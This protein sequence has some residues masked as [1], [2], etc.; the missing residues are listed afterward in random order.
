MNAKKLFSL[1]IALFGEALIIL[2][3]L[4]FGGNLESEIL[5]LNIVVSSIIYCLV[6]VDFIF[7]WV[8][9]KDKEQ[10]QIGSIGLRWFFT[11]L[12]LALAIGAMVIF[13][14]TKPIHFTNQIII[15]GV[16][17]FVVLLG[18]FLAYSSSDKVR[19]IYFEEKQNRDRIDEMK[20]ATK[21]LQLKLDAINNIP[22]EIISRINEL[23]ENLRYLSPSN[24]NDALV[25]ETKFLDDVKLLF[26]CFSDSP[27]NM[28]A[29]ISN[30]KNCERTYKER[31]QVFSN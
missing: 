10:K 2:G 11:Y 30:I 17:F 28:E 20:R 15:H 22:T 1:F 6:F 23:H 9:L 12:Y 14:T 21:E 4:H 7:P 8:K 16:M 18:L 26:Y 5:T 25:L 3:F 24:N 19:E 27:I 29:V 31:K 13:N